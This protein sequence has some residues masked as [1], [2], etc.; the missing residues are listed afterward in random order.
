MHGKVVL[1][2]G[3]T[4]GVG[5]AVLKDLATRG[6]QI[7]LLTQH[8][9]GDPFLVDFIDDT[10]AETNNQLITAEQVDLSSLHS[11]R[12]FATKWIDNAPPRRL[13]MVV[14]CANSALRYEPNRR[15]E[16]YASSSVDVPR[17]LAEI[18]YISHKRPPRRQIPKRP[19]HRMEN[20]PLDHPN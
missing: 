17:T 8:A 16:M 5:E 13:D 7:V 19:Q 10:R 15:I 3:G 20:R 6:A 11:V 2:T 12:Q 14:L 4:S 9:L 1:I 18:F